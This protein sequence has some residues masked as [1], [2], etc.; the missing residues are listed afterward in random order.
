VWDG[1]GSFPDTHSTQSVLKIIAIKGASCPASLTDSDG[2]TYSMVVIGTQCW[3]AENLETTKYRNG[4]AIDYPGADNTTWQNNTGGAYAWYDNDISWKESYGALYNWHAVMNN[5]GICP[6]DW[7]VPSRDEWTVLMDYLGGQYVAGG[8]LKSTAQIRTSIQDGTAL[9]R[10]RPMKQAGP[11]F[12]AVTGNM[13]GIL[14]KSEPWDMVDFYRY[15]G[16]PGLEYLHSQY[17][18]GHY[19]QQRLF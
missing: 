14:T 19:S 9:T 12:P 16:Q 8:K 1:P 13:T 15:W 2:N 17:Q 18:S 10:V 6:D 11:G 7:H 4:G 3:M 5:Q